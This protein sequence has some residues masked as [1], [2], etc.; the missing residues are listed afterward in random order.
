MINLEKIN[1]KYLLI[2]IILLL[3]IIAAPTVSSYFKKSQLLL[4]ERIALNKDNYCR[5]KHPTY[6]IEAITEQELYDYVEGLL[7]SDKGWIYEE[8]AN[9]V[10]NPRGLSV[11][12]YHVNLNRWRLQDKTIG[13]AWYSKKDNRCY[14]SNRIYDKELSWYHF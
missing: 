14:R 5:K 13:Q 6:T 4:T 11:H 9:P 1:S 3:L 8:M 7:T 2:A 10:N 12:E